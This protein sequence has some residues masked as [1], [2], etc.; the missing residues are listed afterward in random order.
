MDERIAALEAQINSMKAE[1]ESLMGQNMAFTAAA[2]ALLRMQP[3]P[4]STRKALREAVDQLDR[5]SRDEEPPPERT[6]WAKVTLSILMNAL[7]R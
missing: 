2:L 4:G 6:K 1:I 7:P 5:T 3:D